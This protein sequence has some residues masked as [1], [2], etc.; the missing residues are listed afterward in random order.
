ML[1]LEETDGIEGSTRHLVESEGGLTVISESRRD[2]SVR[3]D[4]LSA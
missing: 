3:P 2:N 4:R 1:Q